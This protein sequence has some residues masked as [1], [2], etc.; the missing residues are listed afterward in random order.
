M[1]VLTLTVS[2]GCGLVFQGFTQQVTVSAPGAETVSFG[3]ESA[4][5]DVGTFEVRRRPRWHVARAEAPGK[6]SMCRVVRCGQHRAFRILDMIPLFLPFA[7][8]SA[9]GTL[10]D[11]RPETIGLQPVDMHEGVKPWGLPSDR[12]ILDVWRQSRHMI[13]VCSMPHLYDEAF[14]KQA[15]RIVVTSGNLSRDYDILGPIDVTFAGFDRVNWSGLRLGR[16]TIV[17]ARR[18]FFQAPARLVNELSRRYALLEYGPGVDAVI[19]V[20]YQVNPRRDVSATGL[21][22]RFKGE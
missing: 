20:S 15:E 16:T 11:C 6:G 22:V 17:S 9:L 3:G 4:A 8:D 19:N 5:G 21:A 18:E 14:G 1:S 12:E 7:L 13:D 10:G 2:S